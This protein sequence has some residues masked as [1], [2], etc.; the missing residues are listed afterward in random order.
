MIE[1]IITWKIIIMKAMVN[2]RGEKF[3]EE[4]ANQFKR[5]ITRASVIGRK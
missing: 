2:K 5:E 4:F 1:T 3:S